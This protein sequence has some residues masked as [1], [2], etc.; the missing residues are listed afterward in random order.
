MESARARQVRA[1]YTDKT[2]RQKLGGGAETHQG[3]TGVY[4]PPPGRAPAHVYI[5]TYTYLGREQSTTHVHIAHTC[6]HTCNSTQKISVGA[7]GLQPGMEKPLMAWATPPG[8]TC[9]TRTPCLRP[10]P[11]SPQHSLQALSRGKE[12]G[13]QPGLPPFLLL[14]AHTARTCWDDEETGLEATVLC[15]EHQPCG[16]HRGAGVTARDTVPAHCTEP[17]PGGMSQPGHRVSTTHHSR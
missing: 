16:G 17:R 2:G 7:G 14:S 9:L 13:T 11:Q 4:T 10:P 8:E 1:R 15:T 3:P 6:T 12:V 5:H